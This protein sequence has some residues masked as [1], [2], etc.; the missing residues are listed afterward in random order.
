M[1]PPDKKRDWLEMQ[2]DWP[3]AL[4]IAGEPATLET[5]ERLRAEVAYCYKGLP[6]GEDRDFVS[7]FLTRVI[8]HLGDLKS[9]TFRC[10]LGECG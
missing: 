9:D 10:T 2:K 3:N 6:E 8:I 7:R 5:C 1:L 4:P